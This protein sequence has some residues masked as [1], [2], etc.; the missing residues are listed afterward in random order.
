MAIYPLKK[1]AEVI[2]HPVYT[3]Y[4]FGVC[5]LVHSPLTAPQGA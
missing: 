2:A 5:L 1:A 4:P 3:S